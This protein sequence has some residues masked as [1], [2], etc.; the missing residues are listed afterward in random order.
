MQP[1]RSRSRTIHQLRTRLNELFMR[2]QAPM[3]AT[4]IGSMLTLHPF[5]SEV[6]RSDDVARAHIRLKRLLFLDLLDR[7]YYVAERGFS[8]LS[9]IIS[10]D[11]CAGFCE[12]V[13]AF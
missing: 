1:L 5:S 11:H 6:T 10:D 9:L 3:R 7:G 8:A 4:G 2:N 13:E 12:A